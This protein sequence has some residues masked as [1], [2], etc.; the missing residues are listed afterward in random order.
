[1]LASFPQV[2]PIT[3]QIGNRQ[4][5]VVFALQPSGHDMSHA[6]HAR[7]GQPGV[8]IFERLGDIGVVGLVGPGA[9]QDTLFVDR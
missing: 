4:K 9:Q 8:K 2:A 1:M 7:V 3:G 5:G 6:P